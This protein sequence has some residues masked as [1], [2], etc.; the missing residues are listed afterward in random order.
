MF[1][2]IHLHSKGF[3]SWSPQERLE[4]PQKPQ[5]S[6][7]DRRSILWAG[8]MGFIAEAV[9]GPFR[10]QLQVDNPCFMV[11][12]RTQRPCRTDRM[13]MLRSVAFL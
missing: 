9:H 4:D 2:I 8:F 13:L 7:E 1:G 5:W 12:M 11:P 10:G 6:L 3:S